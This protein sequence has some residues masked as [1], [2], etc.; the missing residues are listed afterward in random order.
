M[1]LQER[2]SKI[3]EI[4]KKEHLVNV[5]YLARKLYVSEAT[6]RRDL[7]ELHSLGIIERNHGGA[8]LPN[9]SDEVSL[10]IRM[11]K[12][13]KAKQK[14]ATNALKIL[15]KFNSVFID[16]S[17]TALALAERMDLSFKT[18]VTNNLQAALQ[19]TKKENVHLIFVGG[20]IGYG[21][22]STTGGWTVRQINEFS[23]DLMILSCTAI[24]NEEVYER[25]LEQREIKLAAFQRSKK[26]ILLAD[27][28]KFLA[29]A[30]YKF[31]DLKSFDFVIT[32]QH[33]E[34][35]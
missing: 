8:I 31:A 35:E 24:I 14:I 9:N 22:I 17:S 23:F 29:E 27:S 13:A 1:I 21:A 2:H 11:V 30:T 18:V 33:Y 4:L 26:R 34:E 7:R 3:I 10:P 32:E 16:S 25:S 20:N 15:P 28:S 12:N 19:L 5:K 6:I